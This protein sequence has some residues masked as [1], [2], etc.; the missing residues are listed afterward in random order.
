M[1]SLGNPSRSASASC[2]KRPCPAPAV[3][4]IQPSTTTCA[5][6]Y[7]SVLA[8]T[9]LYGPGPP[10]VPPHVLTWSRDGAARAEQCPP[11]ARHAHA[12]T[13]SPYPY[14]ACRVATLPSSRCLETKSSPLAHLSGDQG[15]VPTNRLFGKSLFNQLPQGGHPRRSAGLIPTPPAT[16]QVPHEAHPLPG[17]HGPAPVCPSPCPAEQQRRYHGG[18]ATAE[19]CHEEAV[20]RLL[21][22]HTHPF[23]A[24]WPGE[25]TCS[26]GAFPM[27]VVWRAG[28]RMQLC[29]QV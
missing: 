6:L 9:G 1:S 23:P 28:E 29:Q 10:R 7:W 3:E 16:P 19:A 18:Q 14:D 12:H 4:H 15:T 8:C 24:K 11:A 13:C 20:P 26:T 25:V 22:L 27:H 5:G 17:S 21:S 2:S